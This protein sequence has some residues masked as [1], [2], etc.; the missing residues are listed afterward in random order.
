MAFHIAL[1]KMPLY[2]NIT[3]RMIVYWFANIGVSD[4]LINGSQ[5]D[6]S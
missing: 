4:S 2:T 6:S 5:E 1:L 3:S